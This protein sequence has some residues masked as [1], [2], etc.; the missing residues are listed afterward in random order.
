MEGGWKSGNSGR[1]VALVTTGTG[2]CINIASVYRVTSVGRHLPS[3]D[4]EKLSFIGLEATSQMWMK[5]LL[6]ALGALL[7]PAWAGFCTMG[8]VARRQRK[9]MLKASG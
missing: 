8:P 1:L 9:A 4:L 3:L 5:T 2:F 7:R 6:G